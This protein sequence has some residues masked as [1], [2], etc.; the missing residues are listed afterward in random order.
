MGKLPSWV[1]VIDLMFAVLCYQPLLDIFDDFLQAFPGTS[2]FYD[3]LWLSAYVYSPVRTMS[4]FYKDYYHDEILVKQTT[5]NMQGKL[6]PVK[7]KLYSTFRNIFLIEYFKAI[8]KFGSHA[9]FNKF[10]NFESFQFS[11]SMDYNNNATST[12]GAEVWISK[13]YLEMLL[14]T[15][16]ENLRECLFDD[17]QEKFK[18]FENCNIEW[19]TGVFLKRDPGE[20]VR[21]PNSMKLSVNN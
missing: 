6:S 18:P 7:V 14:L 11:Q 10:D 3:P 9:D 12:K 17:K 1:L 16:P 20:K 19:T 8:I 21:D 4:S 13:N 5:S 2:P 15:L